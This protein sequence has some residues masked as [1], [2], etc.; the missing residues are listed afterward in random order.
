MI[1]GD[2]MAK[3][4]WKQR[5]ANGG[6]CDFNRNYTFYFKWLLAKTCSCFNITGLPD[7]IDEFYIKSNLLTDG[8]IAITDIDG[9]LYAVIG[10]PGGQPDAYYRP[11]IYTVANPVLG[12]KTVTD[13]VD[14]IIIYNSPIDAYIP[15]GLY[16]LISQTATL[17]A[18]NIVSINCTQINT[19]VQAMVTA[20]GRAQREGA[21]IAL[22]KLYAGNPYQVLEA[23]LIEKINVNPINTA[24]AGQNISE[25]IDLHN[26]IVSNYFQSIGIRSNN[27]RKKSHVLQDEID[28]QNDYLQISILEILANWQAG[29]DRVNALYGTDIRVELNPA[30]LDVIVSDEP[31]SNID[32]PVNT[33]DDD[34]TNDESTDTESVDVDDTTE[35]TVDETTDIIDDIVDKQDVVDEIV[36]IIND[37]SDDTTTETEVTDNESNTDLDNPE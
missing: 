29:F 30:L 36:D 21:E 18:D 15:G 12:S 4:H 24:A 7:T 32:E 26:Y 23:D 28:V 13:G 31:D 11:T 9:G 27:I 37:V 2:S 3:L 16:D 33:A 22:K 1:G 25:L 6:V 5:Y 10:A 20:D 17:L 14:G 8:D 19:R 35:S 34:V